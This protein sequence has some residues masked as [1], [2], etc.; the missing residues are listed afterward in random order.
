[1]SAVALLIGSLFS[2]HF[3]VSTVLAPE[4]NFPGASAKLVVQVFQTIH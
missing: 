3:C 2:L 4:I 1:M